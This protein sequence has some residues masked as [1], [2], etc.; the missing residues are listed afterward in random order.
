M[1]HVSGREVCQRADRE[2]IVARDAAAIPRI[3]RQ[4]GKERER[5]IADDAEFVDKV[6]PRALLE[7]RRR[8]RDVLVE[9]GQWRLKPAGE[10]ERTRAEE[11]LGVI[12]VA[13]DLAQRP[14]VRCVA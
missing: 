5:A 4:A 8:H 1:I 3:R 14:L 7:S 13:D 10:P 12:D 9:A 11:A 2:W 6:A